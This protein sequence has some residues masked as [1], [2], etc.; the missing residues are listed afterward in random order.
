MEILNTFGFEPA[1]F[2]AQIINFLILAFIF[3]KFLYK[4]ILKVLRDR[5]I[6][7]RHGL[8][9][10]E[11]AKLA[12]ESAENKKGE[13]LKKASIEAEKI[14]SDTKAESENAR[15]VILTNTRAEAEK[16]LTQAVAQAKVEIENM[17][18]Q[19]K[20]AGVEVAG[21]IL[22]SVLSGIFTKQEKAEIMKRSMMT[23]KKSSHTND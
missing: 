14:I 16:I 4:P 20:S 6:K 2:I 10:A 3:K 19:V 9:N 11:E 7:I 21:Q 15:N 23:I 17:E 5:D 22:E 8:E 1:L 18:K 13:I 12:L